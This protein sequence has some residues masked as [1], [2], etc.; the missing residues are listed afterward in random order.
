[1]RAP[2]QVPKRL[3]DKGEVGCKVPRAVY[4]QRLYG[5]LLQQLRYKRGKKLSSLGLPFAATPSASQ[6]ARVFTLVQTRIYYGV[7]EAGAG[8]PL[9]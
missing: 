9:P 4:F 6:T 5:P 7:G 1:M 2:R 3:N 8:L